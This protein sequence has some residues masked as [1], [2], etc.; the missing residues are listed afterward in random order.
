VKLRIDPLAPVYLI[1]G[2]IAYHPYLKILLQERY[3]KEIH[4]VEKPQFI[5]SFGAALYAKDSSSKTDS[6]DKV[7]VEH[8]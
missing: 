4:I 6:H 5:V 1:G 7:L 2:V 3:N 8:K